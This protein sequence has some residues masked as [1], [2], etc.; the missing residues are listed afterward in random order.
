MEFET[1]V[2]G[3]GGQGIQLVA[4][5]LA[6]AATA[7]GYHVMMNG[8][9]GGEMR[10]GNSLATVVIGDGPIQ[11]L[12]VTAQAGAAVVLHHKYWEAPSS[13]L[14]ANSLIVADSEIAGHLAPTA[15]HRLVTVDATRIAREIGNPM[16][17]GMVLISA[18]NAVTG[19]VDHERLCAAMQE[20]VPAHR[21][22][23]LAANRQA[24][25]AGMKNVPARS[26]VVNLSPAGRK[27]AS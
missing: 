4:K 6:V 3:V 27:A 23:H 25:D 24:L 18:Y 17:S 12:P 2:C 20:L 8:V 13:R 15:G 9:Y 19:L 22:Q 21:S 7:E 26:H 5:V 1:F 11:A 14:R 16:V 10:G